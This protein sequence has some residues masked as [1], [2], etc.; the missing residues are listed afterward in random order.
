[1][2]SDKIE[3]VLKRGI[4]GLTENQKANL[5]GL[6]L[7]RRHQTV[8]RIDTAAVRGMIKK[9]MHLVGVKRATNEVKVPSKKSY[10]EITASAS[11]QA[12]QVKKKPAAKATAKKTPTN[13]KKREK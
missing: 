12:I 8:V 9:V 2:N 7:R 4:I 6:G 10:V 11:H 5:R 13:T 1:M 3:L